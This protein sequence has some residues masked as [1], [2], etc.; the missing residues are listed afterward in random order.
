MAGEDDGGRRVLLICRQ[1]GSSGLDGSGGAVP[2]LQALR[3]NNQVVFLV[4]P[5]G[6]G[7]QG[8]RQSLTRSAPSMVGVGGGAPPPCGACPLA[9]LSCSPKLSAWWRSPPER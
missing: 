8:G 3:K 1:R 6:A 9:R 4:G 2:V 5:E 7:P